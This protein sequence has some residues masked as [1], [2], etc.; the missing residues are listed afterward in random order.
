MIIHELYVTSVNGSLKNLV[1]LAMNLSRLYLNGHYW[2]TLYMYNSS[3]IWDL[4]IVIRFNCLVENINSYFIPI[5]ILDSIFLCEYYTFKLRLVYIG[6]SLNEL[7]Q[8]NI[9]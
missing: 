1:N 2:M 3:L 8:F 6:A 5:K 9:Q 4:L 7:K